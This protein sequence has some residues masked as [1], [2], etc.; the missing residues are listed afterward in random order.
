MR[1]DHVME[2]FRSKSLGASSSCAR[3]Q[4]ARG[5]AAMGM[6]Y[7]T[8][9]AGLALVLGLASVSGAQVGSQRWLPQNQVAWS[10]F[11]NGIISRIQQSTVQTLSTENEFQTYWTA[12][13]GQPVQATPKNVDWLKEK[14]VAIHLGRRPSGGYSVSVVGIDRNGQ[15][16][17][18]HVI[19][20]TPVQGQWVSQII[21]SPW[22]ILRVPRDLG[23]VQIDLK[24]REGQSVGGVTIYT[25]GGAVIHPDNYDRV[26][27]GTIDP[28][29]TVSWSTLTSGAYSKIDESG[30]MT[31]TNPDEWQNYWTR[32]TGTRPGMAPNNID[33]TKEKVVVLNLGARPT[34]GYA[35]SVLAV[36]KNGY[37]G[38]IRAV[39]ETPVA[40][41]W[42]SKRPTHPFVVIR[43]PR[44]LA[45][46]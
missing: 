9:V 24:Q 19:E 33:W 10:T 37:Y 42:V 30:T 12:A 8:R 27:G 40:G 17:V 7:V 29:N 20:H 6:V 1:Q 21:S 32:L 23:Q 41:S 28:K 43:V 3:T 14:L 15:N 16:A 5:K 46:F 38:I 44:D 31:L 26:G 39:E 2:W 36:E 34:S 45:N 22:V 4:S 35:L 18:V 25:S 11:Q 13:T